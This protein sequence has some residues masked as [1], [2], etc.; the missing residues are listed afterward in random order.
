MDD[1]EIIGAAAILNVH[2][3][4]HAS[5]VGSLA[6]QRAPRLERPRLRLNITTEEWN[7]FMR[8]W[9]T[10][11]VGS[12]IRGAAA[13][14]Q[15]LECA[16]EQLGD[17]MLRADPTFTSRTLDD[18]LKAMKSYAVVPV[19]LGVLRSELSGL[20]QDPDEPFRTFSAR[21]QGKAETCEFKTTFHTVCNNCNGPVDGDTYYTDD[22]IRDVLLNGVV[23]IFGVKRSAHKGS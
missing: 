7:A 12:G 18:A 10:F 13:S 3:H 23:L 9:E 11:R 5:A 1:V 2:S 21:V 19:A 22:V 4:V 15:L 17:I 16:D 8:H 20:R 6:S 14:G